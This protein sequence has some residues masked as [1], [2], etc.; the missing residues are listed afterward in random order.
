MN[1]VI[2]TQEDPFYVPVFFD[3]FLLNLNHNEIRVQGIYLMAPFHESLG[4]LIRRMYH[5]Y[6]AVGFVRRGFQYAA[7]L[8][9][10]RLRL[11]ALSVRAIARR[12]GIP[13]DVVSDVNS[14][15][16]VAEL[17]REEPDVILSV[18]APQV[19][20]PN[21]LQVPRWGC[22]NVHSARLPQYRG[23]MP[24]FWALYHGD[25]TV[26]VTVHRMDTRID[27]GDAVVRV[28]VPVYEGDTLD[29]VM[30]RCKEAAADA[31]ID[32]LSQIQHGTVTL[33]P[34]EGP[35]SYFSFPR[36]EHVRALRQRG[37]RLL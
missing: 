30:K 8:T 33:A 35:G 19:F 32:A 20:G 23:M 34:I 37:Y 9:C 14:P 3:R 15:S 10:D 22:L 6:G 2:I 24:V 26:G 16:F 5:F 21:L 31:V 12:Y 11:R 4:Q 13:V 17:T 18:A 1:L 7:H 29:A 28:E 25:R 27:R 36:P